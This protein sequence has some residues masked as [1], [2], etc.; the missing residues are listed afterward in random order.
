M[1]DTSSA[2]FPPVTNIT[3]PNQLQKGLFPFDAFAADDP[4]QTANPVLRLKSPWSFSAGAPMQPLNAAPSGNTTYNLPNV[5]PAQYQIYIPKAYMVAASGGPYTLTIQTPAGGTT[6]IVPLS[7]TGDMISS[8]ALL[9]DVYVDSSGNVASKQWQIS[10][11]NSNGSWIKFADG[12]MECWGATEQVTTT[13]AWGG[14][15]YFSTPVVKSFPAAFVGTPA[16]T[17]NVANDVGNYHLSVDLIGVS[18]TGW[19]GIIFSPYLGGSTAAIFWMA[20][21]RWK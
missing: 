20:I 6:V 1:S 5:Y 7:P 15:L 10:G 2:N 8:G 16:M 9:F 21:G 3:R 14:G 4:N 11:S 12:T 17:A 18:P 13:T 19:N